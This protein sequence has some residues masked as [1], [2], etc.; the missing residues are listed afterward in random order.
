VD[1]TATGSPEGTETPTPLEPTATAL[2][3]A[4]PPPCIGDC[5]G[6]RVVTINELISGVN[7]ALARAAVGLCEAMDGNH[8]GNVTVNELVAAVNHALT[9]CPAA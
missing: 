1:P 5:N 2:E 9:G 3:T 7:I 4:I 8:D 6:D